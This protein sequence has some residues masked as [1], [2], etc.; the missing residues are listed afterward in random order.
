M[1]IMMN[2]IKIKYLNRMI[3]NLLMNKNLVIIMIKMKST[4]M[5]LMILQKKLVTHL[6]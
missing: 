1:T 4:K 2:K 3:K 5:I 6:K